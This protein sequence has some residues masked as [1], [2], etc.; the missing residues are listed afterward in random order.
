MT[1]P[2]RD[3]SCCASTSPHRRRLLERFGCRSTAWRPTSTRRGSPARPPSTWPPDSR[4]PRRCGIARRAHRRGRHRLRP[5]C[6]YAASEVLGKPGDAE[7]CRAQ[8]AASSGRELDIPDGGAASRPKAA[9]S[10]VEHTSTVPIVQLPG[11]RRGR[12]R[13]L[14]RAGSALDCAGGFKAESLG[15]ALVRARS[16]PWTQRALTGLPLIWLAGV[17]RRCGLSV[18]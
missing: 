1:D 3:R 8:L 7:R 15:I 16:R 17:L 2:V 18:P 4:A 10:A 12:D 11:A 9:R 5:G 6:R 14:R 13:A